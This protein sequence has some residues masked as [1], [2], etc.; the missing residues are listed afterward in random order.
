M[1]AFYMFRLYYMT[2]YGEFRGTPEQAHHVHESPAVD[3]VPL[4]VL[5]LGSIVAG[6]LGVPAA[7]GGSNRF[8]HLLEPVFA[9]V[10]P[11]AGRACTPRVPGHDDR[12]GLM[13]ASVAVAAVGIFLAGALLPLRSPS[14]P[15]QLARVRSG[16]V[17]LLLNK[18]YVDEIY[19]ALFV[20]RPRARRRQRTVRRGPLRDRRRRRQGA[21]GLGVN[22]DRL[23]DARRLARLSD[24]WDPWI[25]DG[26]V[27][28][29]GARARQRQLLVPVRMQNGL[30]QHYALS[31]L[32]G[33]F[34]IMR[35]ALSAV[36][37]LQ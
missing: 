17:P 2:F 20:R 8:E 30:V 12:V 15:E 14:V 18:Y 35:R 26:L 10:A 23:A 19:D 11:R 3:D 7:L 34:L 5:A 24:V 16:R 6:F 28:P 9:D 21:P 4:K 1:T 36:L 29:D 31:M 33:V 32:I 27:Q 37:A 22:G 25:V 13:G